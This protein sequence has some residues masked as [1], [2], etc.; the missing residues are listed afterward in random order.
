MIRKMMLGG[1][2]LG[3]LAAF[4]FGR[5]VISYA[6][7]GANSF[8]Q[9]VRA[10]VPVDFEIQRARQLLTD[11]EPEIKQNMFLI[12][13]EE[14]EL[15]RL[16]SQVQALEE[17]LM[18]GRSELGMLQTELRDG[19]ETYLVNGQVRS[20][21]FVKGLLKERLASCKTSDGTLEN[22]QK[23]RDLRE[24][25]L[26]ASRAKLEEMVAQKKSLREELERI[27]AQAQMV[28]V[29]K[30]ASKFRVDDS[31][32]GRVKELVNELSVRLESEERYLASTETS[33]GDQEIVIGDASAQQPAVESD[34]VDEVAAYLTA[35]GSKAVASK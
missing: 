7:T 20:A 5:D 26:Q 31:Q 22:L 34:V 11:L 35:S 9:S 2:V 14:V 27:D 15:E 29:A 32:L 3:L 6:W 19:R 24:Q 33:L 23:I 25:K 10:Q 21:S 18:R 4:V 28:E 17:K 8:R 16:S 13:R 30:A 1:G 12:A